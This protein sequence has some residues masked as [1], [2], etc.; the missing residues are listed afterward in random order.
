M[1]KVERNLDSVDIDIEGKDIV[2]DTTMSYLSDATDTDTNYLKTAESAKEWTRH[3]S[4]SCLP[5]IQSRY[6]NLISKH[7]SIGQFPEVKELKDL[8]RNGEYREFQR[9][10]GCPVNKCDGRLWAESLKYFDVYVENF[11]KKNFDEWHQNNEQVEQWHP[12]TEQEFNKYFSWESFRQ[13]NIWNCWLVAAVDSLISLWQYKELI[14]NNVRCIE[15]GFVFRMPLRMKGSENSEIKRN[16]FHEWD[17][18]VVTKDMYSWEKSKCGR[19]NLLSWKE[20][21]KALAYV[22]WRLYT[23]HDDYSYEELNSLLWRE[24]SPLEYMVY[25]TVSERRY[26]LLDES[27]FQNLEKLLWNFNPKTDMMTVWVQQ[28][29]WY[30]ELLPSNLFADRGHFVSIEKTRYTNWKLMVRISNPWNAWIYY[31]TSFKNLKK[32]AESY[33]W[34]SL[35][36]NAYKDKRVKSPHDER[37]D[38]AKD[39]WDTKRISMEWDINMTWENREELQW[40]RD[41]KI[42]AHEYG[43]IYTVESRWGSATNVELL[44]WFVRFSVAGRKNISISIPYDK[45]LSTDKDDLVDK[46]LYIANFINKMEYDYIKP[47]KAKK[48]YSWP[49]GWERW[50]WLEFQHKADNLRWAVRGL[51]RSWNVQVL[52]EE[53]LWNTFGI[54]DTEGVGVILQDWLNQLYKW[55]V[56]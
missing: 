39:F 37:L 26:K 11:L 46:S 16:F 53:A 30:S 4:N 13:S 49:F 1:E 36:I 23:W 27:C 14:F 25:P 44:D 32:S 56:Y 28:W 20:W 7:S 34:A 2:F 41:L 43:K 21:H 24:E 12:I 35:N 9:R 3:D 47:Q 48:N 5:I 50:K 17:S 10:I 8:I 33:N 51:L 45:F 22:L 31:D 55:K 18:Y 40:Q 29:N 52:T 19:L 6:I 54:M 38:K 42:Y 15:N